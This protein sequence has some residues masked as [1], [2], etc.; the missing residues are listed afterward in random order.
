[1]GERAVWC[2]GGAMGRGQYG[3]GGGVTGERAVRWNSLACGCFILV[4]ELTW[5][6]ILKS[7]LGYI[8]WQL[9]GIIRRQ[10]FVA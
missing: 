5:K 8:A 6:H 2:W 3:V 10:E 7:V 9:G 4:T 1:M